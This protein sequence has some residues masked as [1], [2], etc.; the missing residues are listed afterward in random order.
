MDGTV[1]QWNVFVLFEQ[2]PVIMISTRFS[3]KRET[4]AEQNTF[5]MANTAPVLKKVLALSK[6]ALF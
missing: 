1:I 4:N 5:K 6:E 3:R 2:L